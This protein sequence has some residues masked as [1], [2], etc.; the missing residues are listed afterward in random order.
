MTIIKPIG[1]YVLYF[2]LPHKQLALRILF[3]V[4]L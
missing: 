2:T 4:T 3:R 1:V